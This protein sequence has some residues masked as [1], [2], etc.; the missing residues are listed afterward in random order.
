MDKYRDCL[1]KN[2]RLEGAP[3]VKMN[4]F[5]QFRVLSDFAKQEIFAEARTPIEQRAFGKTP[6]PPRP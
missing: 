3:A 4:R 5:L 6:S 1:L 2:V